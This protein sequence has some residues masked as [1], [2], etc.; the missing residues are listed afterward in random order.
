MCGLFCGVWNFFSGVDNVG[1]LCVKCGGMDNG[2][3]FYFCGVCGDIVENFFSYAAMMD[4]KFVV[5]F[6]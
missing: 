1:L 4:F 6:L 3:L 2:G 5:C